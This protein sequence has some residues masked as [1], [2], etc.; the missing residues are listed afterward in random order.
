[1]RRSSRTIGIV[2]APLLAV[3]L[4]VEAESPTAQQFMFAAANP[5]AVEVGYD[6]LKRG[7]NAIDA[8]VA[9]QFMLNL[10]EPQSSGIGGGAFLLYWDAVERTLYSFDGR[11]T[12]PMAAGPDYFLDP[13]GV[14]LEWREAMVGGRSVGVPGTLM[15]LR[16][17]HEKFG[18]EDWGSLIQPT[19]AL[20]EGGFEISP[21]LAASIADAKEH[22]LDQFPATRDY[23]FASDGS[24]KAA[25]TILANPAFAETLRL[26]AAEGTA[27]FYEGPIA[28]AIVEAVTTAAINPGVMTLDDLAAYEVVMREPVCIDYRSNE[29]CGMGPPSSG[30][31]TVNQILGILEHFNLPDMGFGAESVHLFAEAAKLAYADRDMYMADSDFVR[32]PEK[33]LLDGSYLTSRAQLISYFT[34]MEAAEPGNPP[35][36]DAARWAPDTSDEKPGTSHFVIIDAEGNAVSMT[37]TIESGFGSRLMAA[38]FLLNNELTDFSF[39]PEIDGWPVANRVEP[40]KRPRSSMAPTI[41]FDAKGDPL[42]LAGSPGGSRIINYVAKTLIAILDWGMDPQAAVGLGHFVNRNG[43]TELEDNTEASDLALILTE[44]GHELTVRDH[45]SGLHAILITPD[46][47]QGGADPR[48]EGIVMGD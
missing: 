40:G 38:G 12:A 46:G 42:L 14:P 36:N 23:F 39:S 33:G 21:R 44:R 6:V 18:T 30:G 27:P 35:W 4:S 19:I 2:T 37:T 15:L 45:E 41:V 17:A 32:V 16:E 22:S 5:Q 9:T 29:V 11:E 47:L 10:V 28:E 25:G 31:L 26:I 20:A 3:S 43:P 13:G 1:M 8:M 7:G 34:A 24:P 48:R